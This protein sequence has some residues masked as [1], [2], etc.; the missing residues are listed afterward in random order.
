MKITTID[1]STYFQSKNRS[2]YAALWKELEGLKLGGAL[3][4]QLDRPLKNNTQFSALCHQRIRQKN[5]QFK[6]M[7]KSLNGRSKYAVKKIKK[8]N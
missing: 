5:Y 7:I 8:G 6:V 3:E 2:K 1:A 4:I